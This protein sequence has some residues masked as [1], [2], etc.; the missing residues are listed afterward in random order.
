MNPAMNEEF[1]NIVR[2]ISRVVI[3][4]EAHVR[5]ALTCLF[6]KGHLLIEDLPGI[7]KTTLAKV[8]AKCLGLDFQRMQFTSDMLP[9]DILG[10]SIFDQ[11]AGTF[12]FHPGPIFSQVLLA[13]EINRATPKTQSALLEAMEEEQVTIEG[14]TRHLG[15]PFFVIA[16][17][18]PLEH[19]GTFP[20]P[21]SQMDR[22]LMRIELGYPDRHAEKKILQG[23]GAQAALENMS[24]CMDKA[25]VI[26]IQDEI[27]RVHTS[28]AFLDYLQD[29]LHFTRTSPHF[30]VGL[31]PRA[32]LSL[33][34][35]A[36]SWAYLHGRDYTI[37]EDLQKVLLWV[38]G[39]R[40]RT[41]ADR[42][43]IPRNKL[44]DLLKEVPVPV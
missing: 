9:G 7:G 10:V 43:E 2:Q 14:E 31:S 44:I 42:M 25:D 35:A 20:L 5:L 12:H 39:H 11:N 40:L 28:D 3:G 6:A 21:E 34:R 24:H 37:P 19:A 38:V 4:K 29:I 16:T 22:F 32:G 30:Q 33:S 23:D 13:D 17:Q 1:E 18:N 27:T 26:R 41:R 36:R 15:Q 8:L